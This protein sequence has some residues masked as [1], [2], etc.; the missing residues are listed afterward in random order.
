MRILTIAIGHVVL[1]FALIYVTFG[2]PKCALT[3]RFIEV[4]LTLVV[5]SISPVLNTIA[6]SEFLNIWVIVHGAVAVSLIGP[7][8]TAIIAI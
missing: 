4:P 5:S 1:K 8:I 3:F 6:V 2:M 7:T